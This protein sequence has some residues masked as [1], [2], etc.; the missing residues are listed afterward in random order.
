MRHP[1]SIHRLAVVPLALAGASLLATAQ[2]SAS[3]PDE[4]T[5]EQGQAIFEHWCTPCHG[6]GLGMPG[7]IAL[8][9]KYE[10]RLPP[11]LEER[12]DLTPMVVEYYVRNGVSIMPFFRKTEISDEE[13]AAL[14]LYLSATEHQD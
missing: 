6:S 2:V 14:S 11:L 4:T 9:A 1:L 8:D 12:T 3:A 7:T 10:G 5:R 13:L